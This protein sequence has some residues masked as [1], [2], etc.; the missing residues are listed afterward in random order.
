MLLYFIDRSS[1]SHINLPAVLATSRAKKPCCTKLS[2]SS[3]TMAQLA[4]DRNCSAP[5]CLMTRLIGATPNVTSP[6]SRCLELPRNFRPPL[7]TFHFLTF[8]ARR[9]RVRLPFS[10]GMIIVWARP[11]QHAS[12]EVCIL[13]GT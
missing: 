6:P 12:L 13:L 5:K 2:H 7:P 9:S 11:E 8:R 10:T 4:E 1:S 3:A